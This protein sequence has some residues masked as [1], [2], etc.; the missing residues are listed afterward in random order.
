MKYW[1]M[2]VTSHVLDAPLETLE[3]RNSSCNSLFS[4]A[5]GSV[6]NFSSSHN[7]NVLYLANIMSKFTII[8]NF[9]LKKGI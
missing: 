7:I 6:V 3:T 5:E 1:F 9:Y 4:Q 8:F 2:S